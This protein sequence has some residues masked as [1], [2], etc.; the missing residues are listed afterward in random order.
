MKKIILLMLLVTAA[1]MGETITPGSTDVSTYFVLRD[2]SDGTEEAS[3]TYESAGL[4]LAYIRNGAA[5]VDVNAVT[6]T[7]AGA[8]ADGGFVEVSA[9][10]APGLYRV[11]WPDAAFASGVRDVTLVV[12]ATGTYAEYQ[13][14]Q[15]VDIADNVW[16]EQL[17]EHLTTGSAGQTFQ[18]IEQNTATCE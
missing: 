6:L 16:D 13:T 4:A 5:A 1:C 12:Q 10:Y 17:D 11:D 8:H 2:N 3:L 9:T 15:L 7:V 18:A 14:M